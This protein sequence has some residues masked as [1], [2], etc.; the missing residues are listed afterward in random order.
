M[1]KKSGLLLCLLCFLGCTN[2]SQ[3]DSSKNY[4]EQFITEFMT[5]CLKD[6]EEWERIR[7]E[8]ACSCMV[9]E[10]QA[11]YTYGEIKEI[12]KEASTTGKLPFD[13][14][15]IVNDCALG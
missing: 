8:K 2:A 9:K 5:G 4:P 14:R 11:R 6:A 12:T 15:Q 10:F 13:Y 1:L 3:D 7:V